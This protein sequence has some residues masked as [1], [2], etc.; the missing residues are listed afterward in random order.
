MA[1]DGFLVWP[2]QTDGSGPPISNSNVD[3]FFPETVKIG[4]RTFDRLAILLQIRDP[5]KKLVHAAV[6]FKA[7][8]DGPL[9]LTR[10]DQPGVLEPAGSFYGGAMLVAYANQRTGDW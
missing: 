9:L 8:A 5:I 7:T 3:L 6:L 1:P 10:D 2:S 4:N